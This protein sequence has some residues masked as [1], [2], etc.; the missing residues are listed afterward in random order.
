MEGRL[1]GVLLRFVVMLG[2]PAKWFWVGQN[3]TASDV[4][5]PVP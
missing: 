3:W 5:C 4:V 2:N 1:K